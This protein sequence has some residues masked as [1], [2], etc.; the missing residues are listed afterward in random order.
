MIR[1]YTNL[2]FLA[3][4]VITHESSTL[5]RSGKCRPYVQLCTPNV[6]TRQA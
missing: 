6:T 5:I 1:I 2:L 3:L 4:P